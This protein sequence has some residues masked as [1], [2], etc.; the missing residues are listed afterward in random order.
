MDVDPDVSNLPTT[1]Q[2][3]LG[4][5]VNIVASVG[6]VLAIVFSIWWLIRAF[7][8]GDRDSRRNYAVGVL[9]CVIAIIIIGNFTDAFQLMTDL[10]GSLF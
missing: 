9:V 4:N 7:A 2:N 10:G 1:M 5:I 3:F 6:L 8:A